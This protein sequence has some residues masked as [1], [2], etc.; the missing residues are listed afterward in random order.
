MILNPFIYGVSVPADV[1]AWEA[2]IIGEGGTVSS[3]TLDAATEF[4]NAISDFRGKI[5]RFNP[6]AS[7]SLAGALCPLINTQDGV[8]LIGDAVD[9]NFNFVSGDYSESGGLGNAANGSKHIEPGIIPN[10]TAEI[11]SA[12]MGIGIWS[13][14]N[15]AD[16]FDMG[17]WNGGSGSFYLCARFAD[18]IRTFLD[19]IVSTESVATGIGFSAFSQLN[20][21]SRAIQ[22]NGTTTTHNDGTISNTKNGSQIMVFR[23]EGVGYSPNKLAGYFISDGLTGTE[24][25]TLYTAWAA[26]NTALG[27]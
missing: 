9:T 24:L 27:R 10:A 21:S 11:N 2:A 20:N 4:I 19:A 13:L 22:R 18:T 15:N 3:D 7:D 12:S 16:K 17:C 14:T 26:F 6:F 5:I 1:L 8:T 23:V 25:T